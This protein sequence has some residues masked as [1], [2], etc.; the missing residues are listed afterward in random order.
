M[1]EETVRYG[2]ASY[3]ELRKKIDIAAKT[4]T[5]QSEGDRWMIGYT[6]YYLGGVWIGYS[7]PQSLTG[8]SRN[9]VLPTWDGVMS[10]VHEHI[11]ERVERGEEKLKEFVIADG[12]MEA[13]YCADSGKL[14]TDACM[15]DP[16]G[17]RK[18]TGY[19]T[20]DSMPNE[21]CD[22]HVKVLYDQKTGAIANPYCPP[23]DCVEV[24]LLNIQRFYP[25]PVTIDDAQYTYWDIFSL[26][27]EAGGG[28]NAPFFITAIPEGI[29][30]ST[31]KGDIQYN[32]ICTEHV[33]KEPETT[34][35]PQTL[36]P[37][38]PPVDTKDPEDTSE[39]SDEPTT[40][41]PPNPPDDPSVDV[42]PPVAEP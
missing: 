29:F 30:P 10:R 39:P 13:T 11:F 26:G 9:P 20:E 18:R 40:S 32:H 27:L 5:T 22:V 24:G 21:A 37:E 42:E 35:P 16:R 38:I 7:I 2:T 14:L 15:L 25:L 28:E 1:M 23:E 31:S 8:F 34:A 4:G 36:P 12:V 33:Y 17:S 3:G 41:D 6:P 19:Y